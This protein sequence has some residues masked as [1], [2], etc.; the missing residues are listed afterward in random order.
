MAPTDIPTFAARQL[1]LLN[2]ELAAELSSTA[3][4]ASQSSPAALQRAGLA[5]LNLYISAQRTGLGGKTVLDL[6]LDSA[7]GT[8]LPEHGLRVGDIVGVREQV[9]GAAKR[10]EKAEVEKKGVDG[11]VVKCTPAGL[12]VALD[13]EEVEVPA[14]KL[15]MWV[16]LLGRRKCEIVGDKG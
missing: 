5:I 13:Q 15:W 9:G 7:I 14:G 8:E 10:R 2:R 12:A 11:V 6:E 16:I 1:T 3:Q 4:L